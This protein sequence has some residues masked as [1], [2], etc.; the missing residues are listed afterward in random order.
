[1]SEEAR[2]NKGQRAR[3]VGD[4][5][6]PRRVGT[7][8][9][10]RVTP[11]IGRKPKLITTPILL[12]MPFHVAPSPQSTRGWRLVQARSVDIDC[13]P[14]PISGDQANGFVPRLLCF[15]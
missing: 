15:V 2:R 3:H 11:N 7:A 9:G 6:I 13:G 8:R 10:R 4:P 14:R 5:D 1:M 12:E